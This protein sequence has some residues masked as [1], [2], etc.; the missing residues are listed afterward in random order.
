MFHRWL[1]FAGTQ[2]L[3]PEQAVTKLAWDTYSKAPGSSGAQNSVAR[4]LGKHFAHMR[5]LGKG[6]NPAFSHP[7]T[8]EVLPESC[9]PHGNRYSAWN[10]YVVMP[11]IC[12]GQLETTVLRRRTEVGL[13]LF[14]SLWFR[15][16]PQDPGNRDLCKHDDS[17]APN[18]KPA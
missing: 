14:E 16:N 1:P 5:R 2:S 7:E 13:R 6:L 17:R 10:V 9:E 8:R 18:W 4:N 3:G 15:T 11:V 12:I